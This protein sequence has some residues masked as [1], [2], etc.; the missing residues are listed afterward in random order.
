MTVAAN[1]YGTA[2]GVGSLAVKWT[3]SA[4]SFDTTTRPLL[5]TV[6]NQINQVSAMINSM[7]AQ[8]G[9]DIPVD[10]A[11]VLLTLVGFVEDEVAAIVE[12]VNGYGRFGPNPKSGNRSNYQKVISD[13]VK[14]FISGNAVGFERLGADRSYSQMASVGYREVDDNGN[15]IE[16]IFKRE[17][18]DNVF[19]DWTT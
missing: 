10:Q 7:L 3:N 17:Q 8:H 15:E 5:G 14:N 12:G 1:S 13:D 4:A 18:F 11:D 2:A 16:P 9:F 19:E 6:E